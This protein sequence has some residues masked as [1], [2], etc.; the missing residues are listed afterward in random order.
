MAG[1]GTAGGG[2]GPQTPSSPPDPHQSSGTLRG[3]GARSPPRCPRGGSEPLGTHWGAGALRLLGTRVPELSAACTA[4]HGC[5]RSHSLSPCTA[6]TSLHTSVHTHTPASSPPR[7]QAPSSA[8][9]A[10]QTPSVP[11]SGGS[12]SATLRARDHPPH[13]WV[14]SPGPPSTRGPQLGARSP[15]MLPGRGP[16][17]P[18]GSRLMRRWHGPSS[19]AAA[20]SQRS[21]RPFNSPPPPPGFFGPKVQRGERG[22]GPWAAGRVIAASLLPA[23]PRPRRSESRARLPLII[24]GNQ[25]IS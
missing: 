4:G 21:P 3:R 24:K 17:R 14:L 11:M 13:T 9:G 15:T 16:C 2:H 7:T 23:L 19:R 22:G 18:R 12:D 5:A 6:G 25:S 1:P 8:G 20:A 10:P